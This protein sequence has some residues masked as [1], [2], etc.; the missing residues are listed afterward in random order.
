MPIYEYVCETCGK[1]FE[2]IQKFSEPELK[3]H[4]CAPKSKV[5]R[6]MSL[7][8][9]HLQG[10]GWYSSGYGSGSG[11]S[12][13]GS[14]GAAKSTAAK[15]EGASSSSTS[16]SSTPAKSTG[17]SAAGGCGAGCACH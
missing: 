11:S 14:T 1:E 7:T 3:H 16:E 4:D 9:F 17:V 2:V 13:G 15:S 5:H 12:N 8:S 6:K 10:G